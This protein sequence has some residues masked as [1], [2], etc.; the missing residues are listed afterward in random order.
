MEDP[1]TDINQQLVFPAKLAQWRNK[2]A[3]VYN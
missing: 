2:S 3:D 1:I